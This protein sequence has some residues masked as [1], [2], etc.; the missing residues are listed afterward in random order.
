MS[1]SKERHRL[2]EEHTPHAVT[3]R[4]QAAPEQSYLGDGVLGAMDGTVTTFAI[5]AGAS[6]AGLP[7]ATALVLGLANALA[8]GFSMA[9]SNYL[10]AKSDRHVV[11]R[12]RRIEEHHVEVVPE[13][14][15]EEIRQLFA[16][17]GLAGQ[18]LEDVVSVIT[19]DRATWVNTML[20]DELGLRLET[21]EPRIAAAVTFSAFVLAGLLPLA[22]L[23][24]ADGFGLSAAL[25]GAIFFTIGV[26]KGRITAQPVIACGLEALV[27]GSGAAGLAYVVADLAKF[28]LS[29]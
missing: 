3:A 26:V 13:G 25:T 17:K 1:K 20:R 10:K 9:T 11:E 7:A 4:L 6:G 14:E 21:P 2:I 19:R 15:R 27:I 16:A 28:L 23:A 12:A 5:V 24:L 8:D 22:P 18:V 29:A